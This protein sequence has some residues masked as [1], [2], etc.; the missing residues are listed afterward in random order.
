MT[1]VI[2]VTDCS[3]KVKHST[4]FFTD[5]SVAAHCK[6]A[7]NSDFFV[8]TACLLPGFYKRTVVELKLKSV[9]LYVNEPVV[10]DGVPLPKCDA[11]FF[12]SSSAV[13][14]FVAQYGAKTLTGME[15]YVIGEP[16]RNALPPRFRKR[17]ILMP[18]AKPVAQDA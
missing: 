14:Y 18:L 5:T 12:A 1:D 9:V 8:C 6:V 3:G 17:A 16:T 10:R 4:V 13:E 11:V 15:I 7:E 2:S